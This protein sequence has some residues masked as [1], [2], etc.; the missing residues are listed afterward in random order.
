MHDE[1]HQ[2]CC[3]VNNIGKEGNYF[4]ELNFLGPWAIR[5]TDFDETKEMEVRYIRDIARGEEITMFYLT[6]DIR[7]LDESSDL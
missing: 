7:S 1:D 6:S 3:W 4:E 5:M 2:L